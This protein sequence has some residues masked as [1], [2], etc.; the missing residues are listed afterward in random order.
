[1]VPTRDVRKAQ[2]TQPH[3]TQQQP[4][5]QTL[6]RILA[7]GINIICSFGG[8]VDADVDFYKGNTI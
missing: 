8:Y 5:P 2:Q 7:P 6:I 1:M 3:K 4:K